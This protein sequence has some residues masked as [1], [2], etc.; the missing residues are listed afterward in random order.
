MCIAG[1]D[2]DKYAFAISTGLTMRHHPRALDRLFPSAS[3][4][5]Q[6]DSN[7]KSSSCETYLMVACVYN[8][9]GTVKQ[10][11][12]AVSNGTYLITSPRSCHDSYFNPRTD[13]TYNL[14]PFYETTY[15]ESGYRGETGSGQGSQG[16]VAEVAYSVCI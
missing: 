1:S 14:E 10:P 11:L 6:T 5:L 16:S 2:A 12:D 9:R 8:L 3:R 13:T 15:K 4:F 7:T